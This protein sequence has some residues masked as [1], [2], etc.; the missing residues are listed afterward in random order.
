MYAYFS[1]SENDF[2][3]FKN[4]FSGKTIE[5]KLKQMPPVELVLADNSI[6]PK[7]VK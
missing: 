5:E 2:L 3:Q 6:Y 4:Q 1:F 7:K